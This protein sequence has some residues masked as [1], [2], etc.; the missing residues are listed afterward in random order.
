MSIIEL[1]DSLLVGEIIIFVETIENILSDFGL[2]LSGGASEVIEVAVEPVVNLFVN[3]MVVV[4]DLL[5]RLFLLKSLNLSGCAVLVRATHVER[6]VTHQAAVAREDISAKHT[7]YDVAEVRYIV[8]VGQG[9]C[10]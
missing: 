5:G 1:F 8:H 9:T 6:V 10:D 7:P 4:T 3:H 2:P